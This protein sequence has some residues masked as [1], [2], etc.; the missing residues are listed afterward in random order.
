[1][2]KLVMAL[3][4]GVGILGSPGLA[5]VIY[6]DASAG[7][8]NTGDSWEDAY[9]DIQS[10]LG[11]A[12]SSD[13]I[14]VAAGTYK[15]TVGTDRAI[16]FMMRDGVSLYGGFTGG[17]TSLDQRNWVVNETILSG[18]IG[19]QDNNSDNSYHVVVGANDASLDG[20]TVTEGNANGGSSYSLGG[21][22][23]NY[24][25]TAI[26]TNCIFIGN[27]SGNKGGGIYNNRINSTVTNCTFKNN[28]SVYGGG[29]LTDGGE[30]KIVNCNFSN[31][32]AG[33]YGGGV[34]GKECTLMEVTSCNFNGNT[35]NNIG[36]AMLVYYTNLRMANCT[37]SGNQAVFYG[38]GIYDNRGWGTTELVN[39]TLSGNVAGNNGGGIYSDTRTL[40]LTNCIL[41]A[42]TAVNGSQIYNFD[43]SVSVFHS[44]IQGGLMENGNIDADPLFVRNPSPG[45]DGMWG[46]DD[47]DYGDLQLQAGSPCI[48]AGDNTAVPYDTAD[49]DNDSD[50]TE[51]IPLDLSFIPRFVDDPFT[52]DTGI[53]DLPDYPDVIDMGAYEWTTIKILSPNGGEQLDRTSQYEITWDSYGNIETVVLA[54]STDNGQ[55]WNNIDTVA[56]NGAYQWTIPQENS[57]Q[58]LVRVSDVS[59]SDIYDISDGVFRIYECTLLYDLNDDCEVN[60]ADFALLASEYLQNGV[61]NP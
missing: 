26:V 2:W 20:F 12:V 30:I 11:S 21:G 4:M 15:P 13:E 9:T 16:S 29:M 61:L 14:W 52:I 33:G 46:T 39:C 25:C 51:R 53:S 35:T 28:N 49:L 47:D 22:M 34:V 55:G 10:A 59:D 42:N 38:G 43:S 45:L 60:M 6:V 8:A 24:H 48:D 57:N 32:S 40:A 54:Y 1:M 58:C 37:L 36:G 7:G 19:V 27:S 5:D 44:N 17:E 56:N 23:Y 31:N 18:D 3:V 50:T 41:W